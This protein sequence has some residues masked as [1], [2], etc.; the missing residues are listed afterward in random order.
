MAISVVILAAGQSKRMCSATSKIWHSLGGQPILHYVL[1][2]AD[3]V[4]PDAIF[5]VGDAHFDVERLNSW[6]ERVQVIAQSTD[7]H[8]TGH[9]LNCALSHVSPDHQVLVLCGDAP[10]MCHDTLKQFVQNSSAA[11]ELMGMRPMDSAAYGQIEVKGDEVQIIERLH[12]KHYTQNALCFAGIM[13]LKNG[14]AHQYVPKISTHPEKNEKYLTELPYLMTH[15]GLSCRV[16]EVNASYC[17]GVNT[18]QDL[19]A[20]EQV[21]QTRWRQKAMSQGVSMPL[22]EHVRLSFDT[23]LHQDVLI[24]PFVTFGPKVTV[25]SGAIIHSFSALQHCTIEENAEVGP[26]AHI[27]CKSNIGQ[28]VCVGNFVEVKRSCLAEGVKSKHLSYLGDAHIEQNVNIGAGVVTCNYD[29]VGKHSTVIRKNAF[30][31]SLSA[32]VA[33]VEVGEGALIGAGTTLRHDVAADALT[34]TESRNVVREH[35]VQQRRKQLLSK[36]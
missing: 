6:K 30:I 11:I 25:H 17:L 31:G 29:G 36:K 20:A 35:H 19:A 9:A 32:L 8:G 7:A 2:M 3:V 15:D 18:R 10:T 28:R 33:P 22:P 14:M 1:Q 16:V 4:S 13:L 23:C 24:E 34:Y 27:H 5:V 21:M 12:M 26:F